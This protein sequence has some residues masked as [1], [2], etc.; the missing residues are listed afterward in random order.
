MLRCSSCGAPLKPSAE[1]ILIICNFCGSITA[2]SPITPHSVVKPLSLSQRPE[3]EGHIRKM[4]LILVPFFQ[5][6]GDVHMEAAGYQRRERIE[7]RTVHRGGKTYTESRT[8]VEYRPWKIAHVG[9]HAVRF[10]S[11]QEVTFFGVEEFICSVTKGLGGEII[12]FTADY[13]KDLV[14][15][16]NNE[17]IAL[18][19][20]W[21]QKEAANKAGEMVYEA[22]YSYAKSQMHEVFDTRVSF[23]PLTIP[24]LVHIPFLLLRRSFQGRSYRSAYHWGSGELLR[25]ERPIKN[26]KVMV[27]IAFLNFFLAPI[28]AQLAYD[29]GY[30]ADS[31]FVLILLAILGLG[32]LVL[33]IL[34][35]VRTYKP[36]KIKSS[37]AKIA[38]KDFQA[39]SPDTFLSS[40]V[41]EEAATEEAATAAPPAGGA[42][43]K[44]F[45]TE[46][47]DPLNPGQKFCEKCGH[48][49]L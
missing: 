42:K 30:V 35:L 16:T 44:R 19:P 9:R 49:V 23:K 33:A 22:A 13:I 24:E 39:L 27:T 47:G 17:L 26:R 36:H 18:S 25:E 3:G 4:E 8:I 48:K 40:P 20:E 38:F 2:E 14:D 15:K 31:T 29:F 12:P 21:D 11:R 1:S 6:V 46:C 28:F 34:L 45:C 7:T 41:T 10:L 5:V 43:Q 37:G 32:A